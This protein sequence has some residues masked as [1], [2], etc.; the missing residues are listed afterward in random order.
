MEASRVYI[1]IA[2]IVLLGI[3]MM[4]DFTTREGDRKKLTPLAGIAFGFIIGGLLFNS[5]RFV[6]NGFICT[7]IVI[8]VIDIIKKFRGTNKKP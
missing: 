2:I 5:N 1:A 8:A 4:V 3:V 7:G 6:E